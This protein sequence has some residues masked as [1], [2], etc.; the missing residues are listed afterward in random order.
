V[1]EHADQFVAVGTLIVGVAF[2]L[3]AGS[4]STTVL[5]DDFSTNDASKWAQSTRKPKPATPPKLRSKEQAAAVLACSSDDG[6]HRAAEEE[7]EWPN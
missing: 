5:Y 1:S 4:S 3:A 6:R 7:R 2:G